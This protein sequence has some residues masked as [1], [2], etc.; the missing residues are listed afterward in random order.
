LSVFKRRIACCGVEWEQGKLLEVLLCWQQC[1]GVA[2]RRGGETDCTWQGLVCDFLSWG[3][4]LSW[5]CYRWV[6][7][8]EQTCTG[9]VCDLYHVQQFYSTTLSHIANCCGR[10][11]PI[12]TVSC[13]S[14]NISQPPCCTLAQVVALSSH[15]FIVKLSVWLPSICNA[16]PLI[17]TATTQLKE[18]AF[19]QHIT[20][21]H[22]FC[23]CRVSRPGLLVGQL[24]KVTVHSVEYWKFMPILFCFSYRREKHALF[25][26]I[27]SGTCQL[28]V[29]LYIF[30]GLMNCWSR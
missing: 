30:V 29:R 6:G 10:Y 17:A 3:S 12:W 22:T 28:I 24:Q 4:A 20:Q 23:C 2:Y 1:L 26:V 25:M 18:V 15:P 27:Q 11:K 16:A 13:I 7:E 9:S 5:W 21:Y 14:H 8:P 19:R